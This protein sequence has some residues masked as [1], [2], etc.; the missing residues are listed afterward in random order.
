MKIRVHDAPFGRDGNGW[1]SGCSCSAKPNKWKR[2]GLQFY[3]FKKLIY[4]DFES[5]CKG[6]QAPF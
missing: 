3:V 4:I 1:F 5:R 6:C 2:T